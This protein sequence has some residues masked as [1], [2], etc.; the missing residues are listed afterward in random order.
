MA[1]SDLEN[2]VRE[3]NKQNILSESE[4]IRIA[5]GR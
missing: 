1:E 4:S 5:D 3:K 2:S